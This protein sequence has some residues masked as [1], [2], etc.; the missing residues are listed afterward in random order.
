MDG[1]RRLPR[2]I[3]R[4]LQEQRRQAVRSLGVV[5]PNPRILEPSLVIG[6]CKCTLGTGNAT[7]ETLR[8]FDYLD[9]GGDASVPRKVDVRLPGKGTSNSHGARP[10]HLNH[11]DDSVDSD[12]LVVN[13]DL[14]L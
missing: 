12:Q 8:V 4:E 13:K 9:G 7:L 10:V 5:G 1:L 6:E 14:S 3:A 11:H 2:R